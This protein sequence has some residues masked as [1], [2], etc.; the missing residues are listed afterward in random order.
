MSLGSLTLILSSVEVFAV[1]GEVG[2]EGRS[3]PSKT[4]DSRPCERDWR[5]SADFVF[6]DGEMSD[7]A[8]VLA[9]L[10]V[11]SP[12][13]SDVSVS[14]LALMVESDGSYDMEDVERGRERRYHSSGTENRKKRVAFAENVDGG[15]ELWNKS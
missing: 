8:L 1:L 9:C 4:L 5:Q 3:Q 11:P 2:V 15:P 12:S 13:S 7:K 14:W 6:D 10:A